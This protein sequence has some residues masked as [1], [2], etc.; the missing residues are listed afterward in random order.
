MVGSGITILDILKEVTG[1][2]GVV[3]FLKPI[4]ASVVGLL[5]SVQVNTNLCLASIIV[6]FCRLPANASELLRDEGPRLDG[7]R[8][9]SAACG[10][11]FG[12]TYGFDGSGKI[13]SEI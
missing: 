2:I 7:G 12:V 6:S 5:R 1:A 13:D 3:P 10:N 11:M 4:F 8:F 9:C